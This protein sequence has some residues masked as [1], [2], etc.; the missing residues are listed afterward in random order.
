MLKINNTKWHQKLGLAAVAALASVS[1]FAAEIAPPSAF[2]DIV[3]EID[4]SHRPIAVVAGA[5]LSAY[6]GIRVWKLVRRAI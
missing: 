4:G 3:D 5:S 6:V 2:Q 1:S